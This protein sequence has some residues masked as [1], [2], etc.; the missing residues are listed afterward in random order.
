M[1][2]TPTCFICKCKLENRQFQ[3]KQKLI[4]HLLE[5][6]TTKEMINELSKLGYYSY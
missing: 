1:T 2:F 5:K 6:H 3:T 4:N